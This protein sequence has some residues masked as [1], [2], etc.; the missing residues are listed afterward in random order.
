M[1]V[2]NRM[3]HLSSKRFRRMAGTALAAVAAMLIASGAAMAKTSLV[4]YTALEDEQL[5]VFKKAFEAANPD[6]EIK[7]VRDS[8]G[9][10]TAR[11]LAEKSNR[12]ADA[13]WGLAASSLLLLDKE[14]V[15]EGYAPAGLDKLKP[16]FRDAANPPKWVG[17]DAWASAICFNTV[18]A[19]AHNIPEPTSWADLLKPAYAGSIVMPNPASSGTGYLTVSAWLQLM[20]EEKGWA[21]MDAL[22]KNMKTYLHSGSKPCVKAGEGEYPMGISFAYRGVLEKNKGAPLDIILPS[23]GIGW[24]MEATAVMK[25]TPNLAAAKKLAD[26]AAT[27]EAN[28][29]YNESYSVLAYPDIAKPIANYPP[30]EEKLMI[31]N[32]FAWAAANRERILAEWEKRYGSKNAPKS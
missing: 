12:Q 5:P 17:M 26:F 9:P 27:K 31:K 22:N 28:M 32:D 19:K 23:E 8:T 25:G 1:E 30:G 4:V 16:S 20:G 3:T 11:L 10:I 15:L 2:K 6:I 21:Y 24:D 29:L 13:V 18:E 7:W 14:G